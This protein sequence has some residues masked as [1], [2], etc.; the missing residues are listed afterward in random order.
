MGDLASRAASQAAD[1]LAA[2]T[3]QLSTQ[4]SDS[5][6]RLSPP[7][8]DLSLNKAAE[9]A[10]NTLARVSDITSFFPDGSP[11]AATT[12]DARKFVAKVRSAV[13]TALGSSG[14]GSGGGLNTPGE[15][16]LEY[17]AAAAALSTAVLAARGAGGARA[18]AQGR[19]GGREGEGG[20]EGRPLQ[21]IGVSQEAAEAGGVG[22]GKMVVCI[23]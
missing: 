6:A 17:I 18:R 23:R 3:S 16:D 20:E 19:Y 7:E 5:L 13:T 9:A 22:E 2:T 1:T 4:I 11:A 10:R 15:K 21:P 14:G 8:L 12:A